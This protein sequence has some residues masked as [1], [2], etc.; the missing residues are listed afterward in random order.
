MNGYVYVMGGFDHRDDEMNSPNTLSSCEII[1]YDE[2]SA[3]QQISSMN[4]ER[5]YFSVCTFQQKYVYAF[6]GLQ[7]YETIDSIERYFEGNWFLI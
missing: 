7:N 2:K 1:R 3:W 4:Q 6:G 5:A